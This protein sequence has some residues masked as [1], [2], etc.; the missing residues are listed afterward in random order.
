MMFTVE[1][2]SGRSTKTPRP[3]AIFEDAQQPLRPVLLAARR[4]GTPAE[5]RYLILNTALAEGPS[6]FTFTVTSASPFRIGFGMRQANVSGPCL[7]R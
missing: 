3:L 5:C 4:S 7:E 2:C 1:V 6:A